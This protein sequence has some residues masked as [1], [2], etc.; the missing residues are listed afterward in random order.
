MHPFQY[1][2][3]SDVHQLGRFFS[4]TLNKKVTRLYT[5]V[6]FLDARNVEFMDRIVFGQMGVRVMPA[7]SRVVMGDPSGTTL[8]LKNKVVLLLKKYDKG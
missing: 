2:G 4:L 3:Y 6:G 1:V 8:N 7:R 5:N